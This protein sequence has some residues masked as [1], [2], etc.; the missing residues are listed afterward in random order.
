MVRETMDPQIARMERSPST[1]RA[2]DEAHKVSVDKADQINLD[3]NK[4]FR[5]NQIQV[6]TKWYNCLAQSILQTTNTS[7]IVRNILTRRIA[8]LEII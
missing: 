8:D 2:D 3:F 5:I 7:S 1:G 4:M 6:G